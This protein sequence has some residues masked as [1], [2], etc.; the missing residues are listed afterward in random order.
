M[1][2]FQII[3]AVDDADSEAWALKDFGTDR[4]LKPKG[5]VEVIL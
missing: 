2:V 1:A 4:S 5:V 3:V